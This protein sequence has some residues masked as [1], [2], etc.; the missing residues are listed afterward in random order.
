MYSNLSLSDI[1]YIIKYK[2]IK[3]VNWIEYEK[4]YPHFRKI[5]NFLIS[6]LDQEK[7]RAEAIRLGVSYVSP[8]LSYNEDREWNAFLTDLAD[9]EL[10]VVTKTGSRA[11]IDRNPLIYRILRVTKDGK[12]LANNYE[13]EP[14]ER[15]SYQIINGENSNQQVNIGN[16]NNQQNNVGNKINSEIDKVINENKTYYGF[17][18]LANLLEHARLATEPEEKKSWLEKANTFVNSFVETIPKIAKMG[19]SI[20]AIIAMIP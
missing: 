6:N 1:I 17:E 13:D 5:L 12:S 2:R 10:I 19:I 8:E 18:T 20:A 9:H 4:A 14:N 11:F 15:A 7:V 3:M 16:N